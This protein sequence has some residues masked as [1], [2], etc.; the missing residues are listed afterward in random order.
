MTTASPTR[1]PRCCKHASGQSV[2]RLNGRDH[3]LGKHGT[4]SAREAFNRLISE[5]LLNGRQ[6]PEPGNELTVNELLLAYVRHGQAYYGP[7]SKELGC[8]KDAIKPVKELYGQTAASKFGPKAFKAVRENM[9]AR[10]WCRNYVNNQ[11]DRVR[12]VFRW[13]VNEE[14]VSGE[15]YHALQA[16][17]GLR[18]GKT[19]AR[20][21]DPVKPVPEAFV[22]AT[23]PF[24][25]P[26]VRAM[27]EV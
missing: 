1:V 4:K 10:G 16:V 20:E 3:Y 22:N 24:L 11:A 17:A 18:K 5:W 8:I 23:M 14:L 21:S 9:V 19:Q 15:V 12:R 26:A 27:A 13:A 25:P 6:I 7:K 2:V